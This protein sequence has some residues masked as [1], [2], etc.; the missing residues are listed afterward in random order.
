MSNA[1]KQISILGAGLVGSLLSINLAKR[2]FPVQIYE[3]RPDMRQNSQ[4]AG[5]SINLALS[6]R[7][8]RALKAVG[9]YEQVVQEMLP[10]KGRIMHSQDG[11]LTFQPY[12]K[13]GQA[14]NSISRGRLNEILMNEAEKAG[15]HIQFNTRCCDVDFD[16]GVFTA[17]KANNG[18]ATEPYEVAS[19]LIIG[20]DGAFSAVRSAMQKTDRFNYK[21]HY[22]EHGY[23][24]LT[25]PPNP[26][27]SFRLR[28][29]ALHIWP[30]GNFMLIALPNLDGS[31]TCTLFFPFEGQP[32]FTSVQTAQD[33]M[34][35]FE[36]YFPDAIPLMPTLV[37]DYFANP[38]SS[39]V[40]IQCY[41]WVK[42]NKA[43]IIGD[44]SHAI[45]PFYGQGMNSGFEDCRV[46]GE[47]LDQHSGNIKTML[48]AF[49]KLRKPDADAI[50]ELALQNFIE[51]RDK[52]ADQRFLLRK[53]IE[54]H[55]Y[56]LYPEKWVPLYSM[57]TFHDNI[58]Y[59]EALTEGKKK[60]QIMEVVM[61]KPGIEQNWK[62]LNFEQ[63]VNQL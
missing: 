59:S 43:L 26:D 9:I 58:R 33:V 5:R 25:I 35:L 50:M 61:D 6:N 45:V 32:S 21:Q 19:Q 2:G 30:R 37:D 48:D 47:L 15:V 51:M 42:N 41:P 38:T 8:I 10:M 11:T 13:A 46:F 44:A 22:I 53:Q 54:A 16:Q 17:Q 63:L 14:I 27:G 18:A 24:E 3:R 12:G 4:S 57:V 60:D 40:T 39:L 52:V 23:K 62:D 1:T 20:A 34:A 56:E 29:D 28:N 36:Q 31:F 49:Q 7:G 55:L